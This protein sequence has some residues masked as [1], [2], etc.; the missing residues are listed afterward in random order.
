MYNVEA[1]VA[2]LWRMRLASLHGHVTKW[3]HW[4]MFIHW[5]NYYTLIGTN[6]T[7]ATNDYKLRLA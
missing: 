6:C 1:N 3:W 7:A 4:G 5:G 2:L